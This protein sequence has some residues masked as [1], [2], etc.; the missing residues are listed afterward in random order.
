MEKILGQALKKEREMRGL[1][2]ADIANETRIGTRYLLALENEDFTLFAGS[3]YIRYYIK[4]YLRACGADETAFFNTNYDTL[5]SIL[6]KKGES[7]PDHYLC[8]LEYVKFKRRK[9]IL[10]L[11]VVA[12]SALLLYWLFGRPGKAKTAA[13]RFEFPAF[14]ATLLSGERDFCLDWAPV[15]VHIA[16]KDSC[17]LQLWRGGKKIVE[18]VFAKGD[19]LDGHGYQ[20]ALVLGNPGAARLVVNGREWP[21]LRESASGMKLILSPGTL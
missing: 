13:E 14:S 18:N 7:P 21:S 2:L 12:L 3:F 10:I 6:D 20:L 17:W 8:K 16:F 19:V 9:T 15:A 4:N 5:Q 11:M 1:S